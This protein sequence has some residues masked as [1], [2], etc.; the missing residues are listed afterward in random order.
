M[1]TEATLKQIEALF[2]KCVAD[3]VELDTPTAYDQVA[4]SLIAEAMLYS[5]NA[6]GKRIRPMLVLEMAK[7][8]GE[9]NKGAVAFAAA[10]EMIHTYSLI[11]DDLPCMDDDDLRRGK[12]TSHVVYGEDIAVLTGDSLL[13]LASEVMLDT[14]INN[15]E[16]IKYIHAMREIL[17]ASGSNGMILGQVADIKYHESEVDVATLDFINFNKTGRLLTASIVAGAYIGGA[18]DNE[19]ALLREIG[20]EIG[21]LF[22]IVDD[23]LDVVGDSEKL[24][25]RT[26]I[27]TKNNKKTYPNL[28]GL[29]G[30]YQAIERLQQ[31]LKSKIDRLTIESSFLISLVDF[32]VNREH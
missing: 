18:D 17:K 3:Y 19:I 28:L 30:T 14:V 4:K 2:V 8:Y 25:K 16:N 24:G 31:S 29:E 12:P 20:R 7:A 13:N 5:L 23:V 10:I 6:G 27:D 1:Q 26:H 11:H 22:Q 15:S 21:L 9:I 32:L